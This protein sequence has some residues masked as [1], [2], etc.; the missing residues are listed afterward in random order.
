MFTLIVGGAASGKSELAESMILA[1][2]ARPRIYLATMQVY[3]AESR[4]RVAKHRAMRAAKEFI[5]I[6][7]YSDLAG[8]RLPEELLGGAVLVEC[9]SNL[10]AN[11]LYNPADWSQ[12]DPAIALNAVVS[13]ILSLRGQ[14][15]ELVVV[16]N[17]V[18]SGGTD[19]APGTESYLRLLAD[20]NRLLAAQADS[21][22]EAVCGLAVWHKWEGKAL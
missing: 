5:T 3:D 13:G 4:A 16:S 20:A 9:L 19:Y 14:C 12:N 17:E 15:R 21:V 22:A 10:A 7:R 8:L 18:F 2:P 11:E 6:E 1:A